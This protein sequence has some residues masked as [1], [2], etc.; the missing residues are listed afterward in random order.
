M[1]T[2]A[3]MQEDQIVTE[4]SDTRKPKPK[5][6]Y[7]FSEHL[8]KGAYIDAKDTVN[9]WCVAQVVERDDS[10]DT[11]KINFDGWSHKWDEVH[12]RSSLFLILI[13]IFPPFPQ[14]KNYFLPPP[15]ISYIKPHS[16]TSPTL[17]V[18]IYF[19]ED[20]SF[21]KVLSR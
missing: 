19:V 6:K 15:Y 12:T 8:I 13:T 18:Q 5:Q 11:I 2:P 7:E 4:K 20:R 14:N 17:V 16:L 10:D 1:T 9:N 21:Q 3:Q